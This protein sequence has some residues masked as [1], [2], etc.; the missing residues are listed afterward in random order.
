MLFDR[1]ACTGGSGDLGKCIVDDLIDK[2]RLKVIDINDP[3]RAVDFEKADITNYS[4]LREALKGCEAV[5]HLAAIS[6]PRIASSESTFRVNVQGTWAT[7]QAA[8]DAGVRRVVVAS[9]DATTGLL[10]NPKSWS[11]QFLPVDESHPLR[12]I[13]AYSLSKVVTETICRSYHS[14]GNLEIVL[15]RPSHI[16]F[17]RDYGDLRNRGDDI[18]NYHLW[19]YVLPED[20]VQAFRLALT[21]PGLGFGTFFISAADGLNIRPTL[22]MIEERYGFAPE[23]RKPD[24]FTKMP[25]AS[26]IDIGH[27]QQVLGYTPASDWRRVWQLR[28]SA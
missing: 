27:A 11:P 22:E 13:E 25:T 20:A 28:S 19:T 3:H 17:P 8:E 1:I 18:H 15:L 10:Y 9:S 23:I 12:P 16:V 7:L 26:I 21:K 24:I 5:I 2:C 4:K 6:S 14:R